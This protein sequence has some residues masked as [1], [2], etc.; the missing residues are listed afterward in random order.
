[1]WTVVRPRWLSYQL[2][3]CLQC[4][5]PGFDPWVLS[6]GW[7]DPLEKGTATH[8]TILTRG[9][10][11]TAWSMG[12]QSQTRLSD[13]TFH[14]TGIL[15]LWLY[16]A[17]AEIQKLTMKLIRIGFDQWQHFEQNFGEALKSKSDRETRQMSSQF[18]FSS[19]VRCF[20][21]FT[22]SGPLCW[23]GC[24]KQPLRWASMIPLVGIQFL[25]KTPLLEGAQDL[26]TY[27]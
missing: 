26:L 27:I 6:L 20:L 1:M 21:S 14:F 8:S 25:F 7:E 2:R 18:S 12:S 5:R 11:W 9:I 19:I 4:G 13:F 15:L 17:F 10:S 3:I 23:G 16:T 24:G 22:K